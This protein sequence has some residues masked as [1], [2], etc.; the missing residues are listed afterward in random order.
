[1]FPHGKKRRVF[2]YKKVVM[3]RNPVSLSLFAGLRHGY[4]YGVSVVVAGAQANAL[5]MEITL[6]YQKERKEFGRPVNA[7]A[8]SE[9]TV[10]EEFEHEDELVRNHVE[11]NP[12]IL[13]IQA[14][15]DMSQQDV[16]ASPRS[17][18][19]RRCPLISPSSTP[20]C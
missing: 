9:V 12:T 5:G 10:L 4:R 14:K 3:I 18:S 20:E 16:C 7:F 6:F 19:P 2:C 17:R 13:D 8:P 1:M 11:R 15:P